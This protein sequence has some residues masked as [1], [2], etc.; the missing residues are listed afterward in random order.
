M[1]YYSNSSAVR[2]FRYIA[3]LQLKKAQWLISMN[4]QWGLTPKYLPSIPNIYRLGQYDILTLDFCPACADY[5]KSLGLRCNLDAHLNALVMEISETK[6]YNHG[7]LDCLKK[8]EN[9]MKCSDLDNFRPSKG[10]FN[11]KVIDLSGRN[12]LDNV[13]GLEI[14]SALIFSPYLMSDLE[15]GRIVDLVLPNFKFLDND[16]NDG[17]YF[18]LAFYMDELVFNIIKM[19]TTACRKKPTV[20]DLV[21]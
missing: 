21:Y 17:S 11:W 1:S 20:R 10:W 2:S 15:D 6:A 7:P 4:P 8:D 13:A 16:K 9:S 12:S 18:N 3:E 5:N 19:P 14:I